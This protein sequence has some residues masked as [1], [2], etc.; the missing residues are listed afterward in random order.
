M[1]ADC[2]KFEVVTHVHVTGACTNNLKL[3][4]VIQ[5]YRKRTDDI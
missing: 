5:N 3:N 4:C 1:T 2:K